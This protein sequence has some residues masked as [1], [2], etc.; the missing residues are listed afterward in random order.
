MRCSG[1]R[2][3]GD[4]VVAQL[5]DDGG[6]APQHRRRIMVAGNDDGGDS[7]AMQSCKGCVVKLFALCRRVDAIEDIS[8]D[9]N[10]ID[11][12]LCYRAE[13]AFQKALMVRMTILIH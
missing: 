10:G 3:I 13:K 1:F 7:D 6:C 4:D 8:A 11:G 5:A 2:H 9:D 12:L